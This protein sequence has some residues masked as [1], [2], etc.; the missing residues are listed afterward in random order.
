[1]TT[2]RLTA[3]H[4]GVGRAQ[5]VNGRI[6]KVT[7]HP[8]D[9][10]PSPIN[11]NI[12]SSL[13]G[14]ARILRPAIRKSWLEGNRTAKPRGRDA[15]VEVSWG[16]ALDLIADEV[17]RVRRDH[18]NESIFAGSYG[19]SSAG[20]FHH[21]QSQLKRFL[22][23]VGGFSFSEG[24]YSYNAA[25]VMMPYIVGPFRQHV[26]QATRWTVIADHS[27][28]VVMFGGMAKRNTQVSDGGIATHRMQDNIRKCAQNGVEFVNIS[29]LRSDTD[30]VLKAEW[31]PVHPGSDTALMLGL[32]FVL[33]SEDLL[34]H[35][36]LERYCV[37]FDHFEAYLSGKADGIPK[38]PEWAA[39]YTGCSANGIRT[40]ARRMAK[41]RCMISVAA[42]VQR[43]DYGEQPLWMA[44]TLAAMLGQIGLPGGGYVI[45]YGVN[46]NVGNMERLFRW[47]SLPQGKN[48]VGNYI[49]VAMI[50][51]MLLNPR[52]TYPYRGETRTFPDAR[53][54]WW[55][56]G[57]PFHHHQDLGRL[58]EAFQ[59][60][61]TVIVNDLNWTTMARHADIVLPVAAAQEREDFGAGKSDNALVPMH[62][63]ADAPGEARVEYDIYCDLAARLGTKNA[64]SEQRSS[65]DWMKHIWNQTQETGANHGVDLPDWDAFQTGD[66]IKIPDPSPNQ[67]FLAEFRSDPVANP[68]PTPSGRIEIYS[69]TLAS[70]DLPD[71]KGHA[72]FFPPRDLETGQ[73]DL[74]L[75]SGQPKTRLHSQLDNGDYSLSHKIK[76]RE[77]VLIHP[78]DATRRGVS[79]GDIVEIFNA[80]GRCMAGAR[81]TDE[82][83]EGSIFLWTGAWW[84]PDFS[85]PQSRDRHGNPNVLTHD[86]R[87]SNLSQSPASHSAR[88]SLHR[89]EGDLPDITVHDA[90][91]LYSE[92]GRGS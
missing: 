5:I 58:H 38:T 81:V 57:N 85:A 27:D 15:F 33:W 23:T 61:E 19:W 25:L 20:R 83:L 90:P 1:M 12:A 47:G 74:Y 24:N 64:F 56:G 18:G 54:V 11:D 13:N 86:L 45:G 7:G 32:A 91:T 48:P 9:P 46:G 41:S 75:L 28:L 70:F 34:D 79:D 69:E 92:P 26:A 44:V 29:P 66:V 51:E 14:R 17:Q 65:L 10:D 68:L 8:S 80:R 89:F 73:G 22:N 59:R 78:K 88:V 3:N 4:W 30:P 43:A 63:L 62:K 50:A 82:I 76:G 67:V 52:G 36:F 35:A 37:G 6:A 2:S 39:G 53:L 40:L 77:P 21:A 84:D 87:T 31:M 72:S 16:H 55:A 49:P 42:G 71:C 60:P